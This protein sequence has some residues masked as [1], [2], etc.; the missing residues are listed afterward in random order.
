L[1][2]YVAVRIPTVP[3]NPI[4]EETLL[5]PPF[6]NRAG[7]SEWAMVVEAIYAVTL[8]E[9]EHPGHSNF[10]S[11]GVVSISAVTYARAR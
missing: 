1:D 11:L 10:P 7:R 5:F 9:L 4:D 6:E 2:F 8:A 3:C